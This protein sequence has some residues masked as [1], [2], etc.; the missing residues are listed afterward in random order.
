MIGVDGQVTDLY[1][2]PDIEQYEDLHLLTLSESCAAL[3]EQVYKIA[4]ALPDRKRQV[5]EAYISTR[6]DLEVETV[7]TA[8]RWGKCHY[9]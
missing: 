2:L 7:K 8:L 6:N 1:K 9:K 4:K 5:V 3:E